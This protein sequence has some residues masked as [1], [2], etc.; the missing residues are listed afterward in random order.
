V[1]PLLSMLSFTLLLL[2]VRPSFFRGA[3]NMISI[4]KN[5]TCSLLSSRANFVQAVEGDYWQS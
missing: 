5:I 2:V 4:R 1:L 3:Q